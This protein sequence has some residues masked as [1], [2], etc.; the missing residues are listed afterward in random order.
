MIFENKVTVC[1]ERGENKQ[2]YL[3][4]NFSIFSQHRWVTTDMDDS[5]NEQLLLFDQVVLPHYSDNNKWHHLVVTL[6]VPSQPHTAEVWY[7]LY[8][9]KLVISLV[10]NNLIKNLLGSLKSVTF[11]TY[12]QNWKSW[13]KV[14]QNVSWWFHFQPAK[15]VDNPIS[16]FLFNLFFSSGRCHYL[17]MKVFINRIWLVHIETF[18]SFLDLKNINLCHFWLKPIKKTRKNR[19]F[20]RIFR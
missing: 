4:S 1:E 20:Q 7:L 2:I 15:L 9:A 18:L 19:K 5:N 16:I 12:C 6:V 13:K 3:T 8:L 14:N 17:I 11:C 10:V